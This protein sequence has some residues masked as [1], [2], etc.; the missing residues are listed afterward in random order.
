MTS[1]VM[2]VPPVHTDAWSMTTTQQT[3]TTTSTIA[4][5]VAGAFLLVDAVI[6]GA[7]GLAYLLAGGWIADWLGA[8]E[9]LIRALG[10]FLVAVGAG[11]AVL[12][13][14][15]SISRRWVMALADLNIMWVLA[16]I[17]YAVLGG[18][19]TLGVVWTLLQA[20]VVGV[21]ASGQVWLARKG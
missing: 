15:R 21:F 13:S 5:P 20:G 1:E 2:A 9:S 7:N 3:Q 17:A 14:R 19:T 18:L 10:V 8:G 12:G 6:T 16:S 4:L 11:V